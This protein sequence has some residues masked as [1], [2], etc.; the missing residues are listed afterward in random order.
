MKLKS[1]LFLTAL[2]SVSAALANQNYDHRAQ[3]E[4]LLLPTKVEI[5]ELDGEE[6]KV[7]YLSEKRNYQFQ[8]NFEKSSNRLGQLTEV[9]GVANQF[10]AL[11]ERIYK[12]IEKGRPVLNIS[13][14]PISILPKRGDDYVN[15]EDLSHWSAPVVKKYRVEFKNLYGIQTAAFSMMLFYSHSGTDQGKGRYI[16]GAQIKPYDV[17]LLWGYNL[18]VS[19]K[20][21][22]VLNLGT[23]EQPVAGAVLALDYKVSTVLQ[24]R[25]SSENFF[26]TGLGSTQKL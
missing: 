5:Y 18:D 15:A 17:N 4:D 3:A 7:L 10:V 6:Q 16:T 21:Q 13:S 8:K 19:F 20:L 23:H 2:L 22:S 12:I 25:K 9:I 11:G 14:E 24:T 26:I 1:T